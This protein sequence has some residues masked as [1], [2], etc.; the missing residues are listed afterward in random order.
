MAATAKSIKSL[1]LFSKAGATPL[2]LAKIYKIVAGESDRAVVVIVASILED[3]LREKIEKFLFKIEQQELE[4]LALDRSGRPLSGF[5]NKIDLAFASGLID[6]NCRD[7]L[8]DIREMRNACAHSSEHIDFETPEL[9]AVHNRLFELGRNV[10]PRQ[11]VNLPKDDFVMECLAQLAV[12]SLGSKTKIHEFIE[13][14]L[15]EERG[16]RFTPEK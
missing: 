8:H 12:I 4:A 13:D 14:A 2:D 16:S 10:F 7:Q 5:S 3:F 11:F 6:K 9:L 1:R 15:G